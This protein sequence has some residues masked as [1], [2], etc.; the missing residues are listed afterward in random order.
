[1][2]PEKPKVE[3][4]LVELTHI[5]AARRDKLA[6]AAVVSF[7]DVAALTSAELADLVG[8]SESDAKEVITE[9][10]AKEDTAVA[11]EESTKSSG[12]GMRPFSFKL[13]L[14]L[15][16]T[17]RVRR[18]EL[19]NNRSS[20]TILKEAHWPG[21]TL[22]DLIVAEAGIELDTDV[23]GVAVEADTAAVPQKPTSQPINPHSNVPLA[24]SLEIEMVTI[25]DDQGVPPDNII[26]HEHDWQIQVD[27]LLN[28]A[29]QFPGNGRWSVHA[30]LESIGKGP[31]YDLTLNKAVKLKDGTPGNPDQLKYKVQIPINASDP[32]TVQSGIYK[33]FVSITARDENNTP[34]PLAAFKDGGMLSVY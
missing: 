21:A 10:Q 17:N 15:D 6:A 22:L 31:E 32:D 1:M 33:M 11:S 2:V 26:Y 24:D 3:D 18:T 34:L 20:K 14:L 13:D 8:I 29:S 27:W 16:H 4:D 5:G 30:F 7:A 23:E 25:L 19:V 28:Q 9:A 12:N